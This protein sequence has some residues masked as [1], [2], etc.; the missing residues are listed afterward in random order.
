[1]MDDCVSMFPED[2][3]IYLKCE[4][5]SNDHLLAVDLQDWSN[6]ERRP[7][8]VKVIFQPSLNYRKPFW[9]RLRAAF[10][11]VLG[12]PDWHFDEMV[13]PATQLEEVEKLIRRARSAAK[14]RELS[15]GKWKGGRVV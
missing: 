7:E 2:E 4:C 8:D 3:R 1:M 14:L 13:V 6:E 11:Y 12:K 15:K 10:R 5:H 9:E